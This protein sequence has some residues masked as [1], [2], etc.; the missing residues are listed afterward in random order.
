MFQTAFNVA[1]FAFLGEMDNFFI[2][3]EHYFLL[4]MRT[5]AFKIKHA[6]HQKE[7]T[8]QSLTDNDDIQVGFQSLL[9]GAVLGLCGA[10]KQRMLGDD[11][12]INAHTNNPH[13]QRFL[14]LLHSIDVKHR[15]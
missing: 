13:F 8:L 9:R 5:F 15:P 14:D 3:L 7:I 4:K 10:L 2:P 12:S 6:M 11:V 1:Y